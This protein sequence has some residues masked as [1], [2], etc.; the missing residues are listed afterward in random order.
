MSA[1]RRGWS[2]AHRASTSTSSSPTPAPSSRV[3]STRSAGTSPSDVPSTTM[4]N[5]TCSTE[6]PALGTSPRCTCST[7][8]YAAVRP[9]PPRNEKD[10]FKACLYARKGVSCASFACASSTN[11]SPNKK[12]HATP[13]RAPMLTAPPAA[14]RQL[15]RLP[16]RAC[17]RDGV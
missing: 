3:S 14:P 9:V 12:R 4:A 8:K 15:L 6:A 5:A 17:V 7:L 11:A 2:F 1:S 16:V 13:R 10:V